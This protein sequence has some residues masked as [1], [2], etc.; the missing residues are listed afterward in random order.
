MPSFLL[1]T[2]S[3]APRQGVRLLVSIRA[4]QGTSIGDQSAP[5]VQEVLIPTGQTSTV[6]RV[7]LPESLDSAKDQLSLTLRF[8]DSGYAINPNG[9]AAVYRV[10]NLAG[11][12]PARS[13][14]AVVG[15]I[16]DD[17]L[18]GTDQ[19]DR[20]EGDWGDD[21]IHGEA[22]DDFLSGDG[23]DDTITGG[24]GQDEVFGGIGNDTIKGG[25]GNRPFLVG[26]L[27]DDR[28]EGN[29][30]NDVINGQIG[31]DILMGDTGDDLITAGP[32]ND[33][34]IGGAGTDIL[35]GGTGTDYFQLDLSGNNLDL[36][37]DFNIC[38]RRS[39]DCAHRSLP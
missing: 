5:L 18:T 8:T 22:G 38:R 30:G 28:I 7:K 37:A 1:S 20:I 2:G 26:G 15:T 25:K 24:A 27:G 32:G 16:A 35:L 6:V 14:K 12:T 9:A 3:P 23:G 29:D 34:L 13:G 31:Q 36:I 4:P 33:L 19:D 17:V 10:D 39:T 21:T 11:T